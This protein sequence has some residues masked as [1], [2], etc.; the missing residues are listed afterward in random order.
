MILALA[1]LNT[2]ANR[3]VSEQATATIDGEDE[4]GHKHGKANEDVHQV[5]VDPVGASRGLQSHGAAK[6]ECN[7][8]FSH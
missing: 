5:L 6:C 7:I 3:S 1:L 4:Q 2:R 8:Q